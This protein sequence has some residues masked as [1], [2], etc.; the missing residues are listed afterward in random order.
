MTPRPRPLLG[1]L[2]GLLLGLVVVGLL[3]QL[4]VLPPERTVLFGITALTVALV[5]G[6][7]TRE[8][9]RARG[10]YTAAVVVAAMLGGVAL[11][12]I[13]ELVTRGSISDGCT[14]EATVG[15]TTVTPAGTS[16]FAPLA[17]PADGVV[18]WT[19][20]ADSP[21]A[22]TDRVAGV[23]IGGFEIP[24]RT[25]SGEAS[26]ETQEISGEV[27][28]ADAI[29]WIQDRAWLEPSG[30]YHAY[31]SVAGGA[32]AC[33]LDGYVSVAPAGLF[34]TNT[35]VILWIALGVLLLL[36]AWA[37][38]AVRRTFAGATRDDAVVAGAPAT[39]FA[40]GQP[41]ETGDVTPADHIDPVPAWTPDRRSAASDDTEI[42]AA[43]AEDRV[44][45]SSAFAPRGAG[46]D[47]GDGSD[48]AAPATEVMFREPPVVEEEPLEEV[49]PLPE[50]E[51][52]D[53]EPAADEGGTGEEGDERIVP[54]EGEPAD[55]ETA[56]DD[57][58]PEAPS[59]DE[60][61]GPRP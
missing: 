11:V 18:T 46:T 25:L 56:G 3:W 41:G 47:G 9:A 19:A 45:R 50:D 16:A 20:A 8:P 39:G 53:E 54:S 31:G 43:P 58:G 24:I 21:I 38:F 23:V 33:A 59:E 27:A 48:S 2:L 34:A 29:T 61:S 6:L 55:G 12:G 26:P 10:R 57:E 4:G 52:L 49:E 51:P 44:R 37:A 15:D 1:M 28:V 36:T 35:L 60:G 7:L 5:T 17:V 13:P 14:L 42:I 30:V 32:A 40:A 22:V